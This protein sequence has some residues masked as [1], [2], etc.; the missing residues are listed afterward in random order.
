MTSHSHTFVEDFVPSPNDLSGAWKLLVIRAGILLVL[1]IAALPWPI[2]TLSAVI[3]LVSSIAVV[4]GIFD[5]A[6]AGALQWHTRGSWILMPEALAG[7]LLGGGLLLYPLV[8]LAVIGVLLSI[9]IITR[10]IMLTAIVRRALPDRIL[11]T[12]SL[13]WAAVSLLAPAIMLLEWSD[14]TIMYVI[15][16][17]LTYV[18]LWSALELAIGLHFRSQSR[19]ARRG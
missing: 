12:V 1:S 4:A 14:A 17:L 11:T 7:I 10:G 2:T 3:V 8:P 19:I 16:V 9:W 18:V 13:G 5:A 6:L 15:A